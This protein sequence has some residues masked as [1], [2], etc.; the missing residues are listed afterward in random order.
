MTVFFRKGSSSARV[1]LRATRIATLTATSLAV[2]AP[3]G[4]AQAF[5]SEML[6]PSMLV[7][8]QASASTNPETV[9]L[10]TGLAK[11][12]SDL[13]LG[14]L[15]L[16]DGLPHPEGSH[17]THPRAET[18]PEIR[19]GLAKAGVADFEA[20]LQALE[21]GGGKDA[22]LSAYKDAIKAL[23]QARNTLQPT[24]KDMVLSILDQAWAVVGEINA[25]GPTEIGN[26]QDAWAMLLVARSQVD[27]LPKNA[28]PAVAK[29]AAEIA[30]ALD[31][32]IL[33]MPDPN[34]KAPVAFDPAPITA[35]VS[36]LE[37]LA[38]SV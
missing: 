21:A 2:T 34:Q 4:S 35:A 22:V 19:D 36:T 14:M 31:D 23:M 10:L 12:E 7:K 17:F 16:Q 1:C 28:D 18:W 9:R 38:G 6:G 8:V 20:Q 24:N 15:S 25:S 30:R 5:R 13:Q 3:L 11:I 27:L 37:A 29:A 33:S 32:V 26:Y